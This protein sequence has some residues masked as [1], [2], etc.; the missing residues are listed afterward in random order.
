MAR[1]MKETA[2]FIVTGLALFRSLPDDPD[3][4]TLN[5]TQKETIV[6]GMG[7]A[8]LLSS[9][10][11]DAIAGDAGDAIME[12]VKVSVNEKVTGL[13]EADSLDPETLEGLLRG[14][15]NENVH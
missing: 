4:I 14:L 2:E 6:L 7:L 8:A 13:M 3:T 10:E 5:L 1:S 11:I 15:G 12:K 9:K